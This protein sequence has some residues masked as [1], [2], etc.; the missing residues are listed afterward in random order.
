MAYKLKM[1]S[2]RATT[3]RYA[4]YEVVALLMIMIHLIFFRFIDIEGITPNL[5]VILVVW[6]A[7]SEG[8]FKALFAGFLIGLQY[9]IISMDV[10]GTN[11]LT[12]T[13][14]A[15]VAGF[16]Y[17]EKKGSDKIGSFYFLPI[18]FVSSFIHNLVY[19][20]FY[21]ETSNLEFW[22]FFLKYGLWMSVYTTLI[23][24]IAIFIKMPKS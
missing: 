19:Y 23:S 7:I 9:D 15:F 3:L 5:L 14:V 1:D 10:M 22:G 13:I 2:K 18:V 24:V 11:A 17:S 12:K 16:F 8:Q 4:L 6:I 21:I 20:L